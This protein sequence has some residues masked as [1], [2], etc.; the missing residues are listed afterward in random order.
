MSE[1]TQEA[2][3]SL[4]RTHAAGAE[5]LASH[6]AAAEAEEIAI[7]VERHRGFWR[8]SKMAGKMACKSLEQAE[9]HEKGPSWSWARIQMGNPR[10]IE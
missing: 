7:Q 5:L 1:L 6:G 10:L 9:N 2:L 8:P 4:R 3:S